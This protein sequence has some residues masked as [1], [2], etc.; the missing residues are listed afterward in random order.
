MAFESGKEIDLRSPATGAG[1]GSPPAGK[2]I[3]RLQFLTMDDG[4]MDY[5]QQIDTACRAGIR[6]IQ[7]RMK[8]AG[9]EQFLHTA[10]AAKK[11]CD[12][13]NCVLIINDR[14]DIAKA[15]KAHGVHLGKLD[16]PVDRARHLLGNDLIIGGTANTAGDVLEHCRQG[17]DYI[18]LGPYRYTSTKKK[19]SPVL[20]HEG[21]CRIMDVLAKEQLTVPVVA[22]GGILMDDVAG[23]L[24]AG[25]HGVAFS[26]L[27]VNAADREKAVKELTTKI[28]Y[29]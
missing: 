9:E 24:Q 12:Q 4:P 18:G 11:I 29:A 8:E 1:I 23:L 25:L 7:L 5:L 22:I 21:Y 13:W 14:V 10:L 6:W 28:N 26:G 15:V 20:G 3:G 27:L 19:L 17:A 16:M 2:T